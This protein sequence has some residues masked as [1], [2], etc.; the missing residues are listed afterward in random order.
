MPVVLRLARRWPPVPLRASVVALHLGVFVVLSLSQ[1][2]VDAWAKRF[3]QPFV[4]VMFSWVA[5]V[6]RAWYNTMPTMLSTYVAVLVTAWGMTESRERERRTLRGVQLEA[7]P[8]PGGGVIVR[9][10][11]PSGQAPR[12]ATL[13]AVVEPLVETA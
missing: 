13:A 1:A 3:A 5:R 6:T 7:Q 4:P 12:L 10:L 9:I 11:I 8:R 2:M